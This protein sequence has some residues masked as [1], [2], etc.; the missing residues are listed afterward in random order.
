MPPASPPPPPVHVLAHA[1]DAEVT[2]WWI[3]LDASPGTPPPEGFPE[4]VRDRAARLARPA[5]R[6]RF[7]AS[8]HALHRILA[9]ELGCP[10]E[11][12]ELATDGR[13][14]PRLVGPTP[15][16]SGL[17]FNLS[18]ST[19]WALVAASRAGDPGVDVERLHPVQEVR[20]L[21]EAH[22]TPEEQDAWRRAGLDARDRSFLRCWTRKEACAKALGMGVALPFASLEA[23]CGPEPRRLRVEAEGRWRTV[24]V[25]SVPVPGEA[26]AAVALAA[27]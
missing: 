12:L 7:L 3:E 11:S 10:A 16:A 6:R 27:L 23:G 1:L 14:K 25:A 26:L 15:D 20:A 19:G 24:E 9:D 5:D 21:V 18:R 17:R 22:F 8:H 2:V 4:E 13:G